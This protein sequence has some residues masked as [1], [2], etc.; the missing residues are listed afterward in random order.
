MPSQ[1][2]YPDD[3]NDSLVEISR[4]VE[5][6][7]FKVKET[8]LQLDDQL[9][10]KISSIIQPTATH[11]HAKNPFPHPTSTY[12]LNVPTPDG[13]RKAETWRME[14]KTRIEEDIRRIKEE[15]RNLEE[16]AEEKRAKK[17]EE[18]MARGE[19]G[20]ISGDKKKKKQAPSPRTSAIMG[21]PRFMRSRDKSGNSSDE[22][23]E[24]IQ[25]LGERTRKLKEY[26]RRLQDE[27]QQS[28]EEKRVLMDEIKRLEKEQQREEE[29]VRGEQGE[30]C[31]D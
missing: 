23:S 12:I 21:W 8:G 10:V 27:N 24:R 26:A 13:W 4:G 31:N 1:D 14:Q 11:K 20:E 30:K 5:E 9:Y 29:E 7:A 22:N 19:K 2:E 17:E 28:Q 6:G 3:G 16:L 25:R 18:E 15:T